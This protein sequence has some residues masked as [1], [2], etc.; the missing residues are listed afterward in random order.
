MFLTLT[1]DFQGPFCFE[2]YDDLTSLHLLPW[3]WYKMGQRTVVHWPYV[4]LCLFLYIS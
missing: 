2:V 4:A 3:W 1:L